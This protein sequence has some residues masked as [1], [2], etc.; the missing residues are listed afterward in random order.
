MT[1]VEALEVL[2]ETIR[3]IRDEQVSDS[4]FGGQATQEK[5]AA[6]QIYASRINAESVKIDAMLDD[7]ER[8]SN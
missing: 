3:S 8:L 6:S 1:R 7:I 4:I 5:R 2:A